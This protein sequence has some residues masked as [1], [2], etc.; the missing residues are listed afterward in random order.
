MPFEVRFEAEATSAHVAA[1]G[2]LLTVNNL[3]MLVQITFEAER[4]I[5]CLALK[6]APLLTV[7]N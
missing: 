6:L 7:F 1:E 4:H 3:D 5:A 2:T